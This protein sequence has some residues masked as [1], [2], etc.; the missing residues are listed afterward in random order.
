MWQSMLHCVEKRTDEGLNSHL[1]HVTHNTGVCG[2]L[3]ITSFS[4]PQ[5][6]L[7]SSKFM[8][9]TA[10]IIRKVLVA[11]IVQAIY[12]PYSWGLDDWPCETVYLA[13]HLDTLII[14]PYHR[15]DYVQPC[16]ANKP[17]KSKHFCF[18][19]PNIVTTYSS[20]QFG[21]FPRTPTAQH[22]STTN[23][24]Q[25]TNTKPL[26][27]R[28]MVDRSLS[29]RYRRVVLSQHAGSGKPAAIQTIIRTR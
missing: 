29:T 8:I 1:L 18:M 4:T 19:I 16:T 21:T 14:K 26:P 24:L 11:A 9:R 15:Y 25:V 12:N 7:N 10:K 13:L 23:K 6:W 3:I 20:Y 27:C 22:R 17:R 2:D 5:M 28:S